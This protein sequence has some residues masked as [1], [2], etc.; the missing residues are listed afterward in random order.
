MRVV[1]SSGRVHLIPFGVPST[2][3]DRVPWTVRTRSQ[4]QRPIQRLSKR[5]VEP[6]LSG[7]SVETNHRRRQ[8]RRARHREER[9]LS[10]GGH[11]GAW[12]IINK[13]S[14]GL[15]EE[16]RPIHHPLTELCSCDATLESKCEELLDRIIKTQI[17]L[18][19]T[20][21]FV[22]F[23]LDQSC[24]G[25][26][27]GRVDSIP[28]TFIYFF[29]WDDIPNSKLRD[30]GSVVGSSIGCQNIPR[31]FLQQYPLEFDYNLVH[32]FTPTD[33]SQLK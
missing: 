25:S 5:V 33:R 15:Y 28:S 14:E 13:T 19:S 31:L 3:F 16:A 30:G 1:M 18:F 27:A 21:S 6:H 10:Y 9:L 32:I 22:M 8:G 23:D 20:S 17:Y 29:V 11:S 7:Q 24:L 2:H 26:T 12:T 4:I